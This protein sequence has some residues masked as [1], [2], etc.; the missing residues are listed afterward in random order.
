MCLNQL[1]NS[2]GGN[3][4]LLRVNGYFFMWLWKKASPEFQRN[5]DLSV[6]LHAVWMLT[7]WC[8]MVLI[9]RDSYLSQENSCLYH[10]SHFVTTVNSVSCS[11]F[12]IKAYSWQL[13]WGW[14]KD[15]LLYS[16]TIQDET[17]GHYY[18]FLGK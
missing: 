5:D 15:K 3:I 12:W 13:K 1:F 8:K 14:N 2:F 9:V 16:Q 7:N 6:Y 18:L 10:H 4:V 17:H 11:T